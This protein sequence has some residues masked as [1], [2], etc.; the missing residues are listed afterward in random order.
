MSDNTTKTIASAL[1][2]IVNSDAQF[3]NDSRGKALLD[4]AYDLKSKD[5]R[6]CVFQCSGL[7]PHIG[8]KG[9]VRLKEQILKDTMEGR[10]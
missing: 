8:D 3:L 6:G 4:L 9:F 2:M 7:P 1:E 10:R 5:A